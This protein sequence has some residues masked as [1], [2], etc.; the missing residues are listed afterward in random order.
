MMT[1]RDW[2][3]MARLLAPATLVALVSRPAVAQRLVGSPVRG[4]ARAVG[5]DALARIEART[6]SAYERAKTD[7][8]F[9]RGWNDRDISME[10]DALIRNGAPEGPSCRL[11]R[12]PGIPDRA[13]PAELACAVSVACETGALRDC[14]VTLRWSRT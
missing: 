3:A 2:L 12:E 10:I 4:D 14:T 7:P 8:D 6:R 11:V 9:L 5:R 13:Q 1:R